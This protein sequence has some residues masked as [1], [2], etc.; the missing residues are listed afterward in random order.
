MFKNSTPKDKSK[1]LTNLPIETVIAEGITIQGD[2]LGEGAIRIDGKVEGNVQLSKGVI[3]G[4]K[5]EIIG[6]V[7]SSEVIVFGKLNGNLECK[8]L[9][10][11]STGKIDGNILVN[12]FA[13]DMGGKYN[14]NL[15]MTQNEINLNEKLEIKRTAE[16]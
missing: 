14:G 11:K 9:Y 10:I 13:V 3:L 7:K 6:S 1:N 15:K 5:A 16:A 2:I 4:E 8:D 12:A